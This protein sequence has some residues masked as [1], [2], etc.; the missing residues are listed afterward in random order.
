MK[1]TALK[2]IFSHLFDNKGLEWNCGAFLEVFAD[3]GECFNLF[4]Q[5]LQIGLINIQILASHVAEIAA[6]TG[7]PDVGPRKLYR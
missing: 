6:D 4:L 7:K 2:W 5:S 1:T 3:G